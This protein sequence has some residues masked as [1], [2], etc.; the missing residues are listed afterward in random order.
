MSCLNELFKPSISLFSLAICLFF[1]RNLNS[2]GISIPQPLCC[3]SWHLSQ[4]LQLIHHD[5]RNTCSSQ[6]SLLEGDLP[7]HH[8]LLGMQ[9]L[10]V[11]REGCLIE[12]Q[13]IGM[14]A[15]QK[16]STEGCKQG[17]YKPGTA[18]SLYKKEQLLITSIV[19]LT[20]AITLCKEG[21]VLPQTGDRWRRVEKPHLV[22]NLLSTLPHSGVNHQCAFQ[23][24]LSHQRWVPNFLCRR[25]TL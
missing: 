24:W 20:P 10:R 1:P 19:T 5:L 7:L 3:T 14:W 12:G 22:W 25:G 4:S 2:Q 11:Y 17:A 23:K 13:N 8:S 15:K 9:Q 6:R 16:R 21:A 18:F